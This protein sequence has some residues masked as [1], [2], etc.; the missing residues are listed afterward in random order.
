MD[1]IINDKMVDGT[2]M[3]ASFNSGPFNFRDAFGYYIQIVSS[4]GTPVGTIKLQSSVDAV[5]SAASVTN[6]DD[7]PGASSSISGAGITS[8][9]Q[10]TFHATWLRI[11][12]TR[13]SGTGTCNATIAGKRF[14]L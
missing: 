11:V 1:S 13:T 10:G 5:A 4:G 8:W 6:W 9:H 3:G 2:S 7:V 14:C 12:Y